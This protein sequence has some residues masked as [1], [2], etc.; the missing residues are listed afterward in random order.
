L[1]IAL[2]AGWALLL[3]F[4]GSR[5]GDALPAARLLALP[6]G[7]KIAHAF[8]YAVLG[9]LG[10]WAAAPR[11]PRRALLF[12]LL[13]GLAWGMLDEWVQGHVPGRTRSPA[14]LLADAAGA[15]AGGWLAG[16]LRRSRGR[17]SSATIRGSEPRGEGT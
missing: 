10:A 16:R 3:L 7:D 14:D 15:A 13:A 17:A 1:A 4:V 11:S 5:P 9:A 8:A 2:A 6:G 12:G